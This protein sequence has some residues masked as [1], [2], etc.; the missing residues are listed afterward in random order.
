MTQFTSF[1]NILP[2]PISPVTVEG[3]SGSST[4]SVPGFKAVNLRSS[5]FTLLGVARS[6]RTASARGG[7]GHKWSFSIEYNE[8]PWNVFA[9]ISAFLHGRSGRLRPFF[10]S[11]PPYTKPRDPAFSAFVATNSIA[12]AT[13]GVSGSSS[14]IIAASSTI[15]GTPM[16][17][18]FFT[19]N[20]S[21]AIEHTKAYKVIGVEN[22]VNYINSPIPL[23]QKK[24]T[25]EPPLVK[26][27]S[28]GAFIIFNSPLFKVRMTEDFYE[29]NID[30][31]GLV[32][33]RISVE[34]TY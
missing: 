19:I 28:A 17:G 31:D 23:N 24:I 5:T 27:V 26:S 25:F 14:L 9:P 8:V 3:F 12:T 2:T 13:V 4:V 10:L 30:S 15:S 18:D 21:N 1:S 7:G 16:P 32:T 22:F 6:G 34:E 20:D 29:D 33:Q 11:V